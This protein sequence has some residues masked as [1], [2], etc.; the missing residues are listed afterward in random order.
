MYV[1]LVSWS[2]LTIKLGDYKEIAISFTDGIVDPDH[3]RRG[4]VTSPGASLLLVENSVVCMYV[5]MYVHTP[6]SILA[7]EFHA[8]RIVA[9]MNNRGGAALKNVYSCH[10]VCMC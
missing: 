3:I 5:H 7:S 8:C 1:L 9:L 4:Y 6:P 2:G 10:F